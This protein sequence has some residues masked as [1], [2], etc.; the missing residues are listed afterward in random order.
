MIAAHIQPLLVI[1]GLITAL[2]V[3]MFVAPH[4]LLK[5]MFNVERPDWVT[6]FVARHWGLLIGLV[7]MLLVYAAYDPGVRAAA[8]ALAAA[9]KI[10]GVGLILFTPLERTTAMWMVVFGDGAMAVIYLMYFAGL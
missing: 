10:A 8:M 4:P 2:V 6:L 7:G 3:V 1:T 5:L 9:E